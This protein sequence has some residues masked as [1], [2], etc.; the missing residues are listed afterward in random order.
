MPSLTSRDVNVRH[1]THHPRQPQSSEGSWCRRDFPLQ[2]SALAARA[3]NPNWWLRE[4]SNTLISSTIIMF[5]CYLRAFQGWGGEAG[6][7]FL[8]SESS[9]PLSGTLSPALTYGL[10]RVVSWASW[11]TRSSYPKA[12]LAQSSC[13][14]EHLLP[15]HQGNPGPVVS[16]A[17]GLHCQPECIQLYSTCTWGE[18]MSFAPFNIQLY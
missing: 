1:V 17:R 7:W 15:S 10:T 3:P 8:I 13:L 12:S 14:Y 4:V 6:M 18:A 9:I 16:K 11:Q 2:D 5:S